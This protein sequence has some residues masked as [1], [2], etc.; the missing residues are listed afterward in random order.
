[1]P[2]VDDYCIFMR[3]YTLKISELVRDNAGAF[4]SIIAICAGLMTISQGLGNW[5]SYSRLGTLLTDNAF[6]M[7]S[8]GPTTMDP[9]IVAGLLGDLLIVLLIVLLISTLFSSFTEG[10]FLSYLHRGISEKKEYVGFFFNSALGKWGRMIGATLMQW[11]MF[12]ILLIGVIVVMLIL[13]LII[14]I[15]VNPST[16]NPG[17]MMLMIP[18]MIVY[19]FGVISSLA[20]IW[21]I[22]FEAACTDGTFGEWV[23]NSFAKAKKVFWLMFLWIIVYFVI[24]FA[25]ISL[26]S[27]L[28]NITYYISIIVASGISLYFTAYIFYPLYQLGTERLN[29]QKLKKAESNQLED[30]F[31]RS[32]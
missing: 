12:F 32:Q 27:L 4:W 23:C 3:K 31:D 14:G 9:N 11:L 15:A 8:L 20:L 28:G 5:V 1:M 10:G 13:A 26:G 19:I 18:I 30:V 25:L 6:I 22:T 16:T 2:L 7:Q 21:F 24:F 17:T 29:A